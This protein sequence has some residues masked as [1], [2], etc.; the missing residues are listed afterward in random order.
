MRKALKKSVAVLYLP[1]V[2]SRQ[3]NRR[4][5]SRARFPLRRQHPVNRHRRL[6]PNPVVLITA[7]MHPYESAGSYAV[8][9]MIDFMLHRNSW[10]IRRRYTFHI[11]PMVNVE[12][13]HNG[14]SR[15]TGL[16]GANV[17]QV[18]GIHDPAHSAIKSLVEELRPRLMIDLHHF[19]EKRQDDARC[20]NGD[21][22]GAFHG[23][24]LTNPVSENNGTMSTGAPRESNEEDQAWCQFAAREYAATGLLF[25]LPWYRRNGQDMRVLGR[26]VLFCGAGNRR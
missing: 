21:F 20:T 6:S 7:R 13:V 11:V 25:E 26:N 9:G 15:L 16:Q 19:L 8:E 1:L 12:G 3:R 2:A 10:N 17:N 22:L 23:Y 24:C 4:G 14:L 5:V 18:C